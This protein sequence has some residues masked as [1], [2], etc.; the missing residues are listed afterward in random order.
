MNAVIRRDLRPLSAS[1]LVLIAIVCVLSLAL[2]HPYQGLFHDARLYLL[3]SLRHL[4]PASLS[5][6]VFL[7]YGSQ[8]TYTLFTAPV[9]ALIRLLG[10]EHA[11]AL[12]TCVS[13]LALLG[14][15]GLLASVLVPRSLALPGV[16]VLVGSSGI[17]GSHRVFTVV[18]SF[19][20]PRMAAEAFVLAALAA[21][22]RGRP[23]LGAAGLVAAALCH[24]LMALAGFITFAAWHLALRWPRSA[25]LAAV[26]GAALLVAA[27]RLF[28]SGLLQR[29]DPEWLALVSGRSPIL[30][31][32]YWDASDW[33][34]LAP[35]AATLVIGAAC[36]GELQA[37]RLCIA[38]LVTLLA[39]LL[40][41]AVA[42][43]GL[44]LVWFTQLQPWRCQWLACVLAALL[45][46][47]I[48]QRL[49]GEGIPA[50]TSLVLLVAAW[51]FG[52]YPGSIAPATLGTAA[53]WGLRNLA[54]RSQRLA[55]WGACALLSIAC[56]WRAA[57]N[58]EFTDSMLLSS[59]WPERIRR[60]M[61][62]TA[63]GSLPGA[64]LLLVCVTERWPA[65]PRRVAQAVLGVAGL[66]ALAALVPFTA[67]QLARR[68]FTVAY[69][70]ALAPLRA[71]IPPGTDVLWDGPGVATWVLLDRPNYLL[72]ADTAGMLYSRTAAFEM[73]R[74]AQVLAVAVAPQTFLRFDQPLELHLS[75][76][77]LQRICL[78]G[79]VP[80]I[81]SFQE[82]GR[83]PAFA[84]A[85]G[86]PGPG[87]GL[88]LYRCERQVALV[89]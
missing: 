37:R 54:P 84:I 24:P 25:L 22:L 19:L 42:C 64:A 75:A 43:D 11:A 71:A 50:R 23:W 17:Y 16:A 56:L 7:R 28:P 45:L 62:L 41:T 49:W 73:R 51:V 76:A 87:G 4:D 13:Q 8:D 21:L 3:Q 1:A 20:T 53:L 52:D 67:S 57:S 88:K 26:A 44:Q 6:D 69:D 85:R 77:Q 35:P 29:F 68:E 30:F 27:A 38:V 14:A 74:R 72:P 39:G 10:A 2:N 18:E 66:L 65:M 61:S 58:L 33:A 31:L 79:A 32:R 48:V 63:D 86:T 46:P 78:T 40:L 36:L 34:R 47:A 83:P 81:V 55:W 15:A 70:A 9:A 80:F 59:E 5:Q 82:L 89:Q 12:L 60:V